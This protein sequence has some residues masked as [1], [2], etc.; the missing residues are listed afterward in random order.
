MLS[1]FPGLNLG[2]LV[3]RSGK[4][5]ILRR[6]QDTNRM[7]AVCFGSRVF[8]WIRALAALSDRT[9]RGF[10]AHLRESDELSCSPDR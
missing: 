4:P 7:V 8:L 1:S 6:I 5:S 3:Q 2:F 10:S 9:L